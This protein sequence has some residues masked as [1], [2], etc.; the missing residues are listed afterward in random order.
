MNIGHI[1]W[2]AL[3]VSPGSAAAADP[4]ATGAVNSGFTLNGFGTL[5]FARSDND[6]AQYVRDLS[7]PYGLTTNG[8]AKV[9]SVLGLQAAYRFDN[10]LDGMLQAISRYRYDGSYRP[11]I[12]WAFLHYSPDP[13]LNLRVGRLG[14]EFYMSADSRLVGYA[15]LTVR[16]P[17]D[18]FG[19]LIFSYLDGFDVDLAR[20]VANGLLRGKLFAGY[21]PESSPF[22]GNI[23]W[24]L[25]GTLLAGGY[26]D[27]QT[28]PWQ[29]RLGHVQARF[30][31]E[32]P[33]DALVPGIIEAAPELSVSDKWARFDSLGVV[34]DPGPFQF[35]AMF[36]QTRHD[37]ATYE[38]TRAG[39]AIASYRIGKATP[40]LGY[41]RTLSKANRF[42]PTSPP[43]AAQIASATHSDQYTWFLGGRWDIRKDLDLKAQVDWVRGS[44]SSIFPFRGDP[45]VWDGRMT[46]FSLTL[47]FVF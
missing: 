6:Q 7:Q 1:L 38:D 40:Y 44:P 41:S 29:I 34:Y 12:S 27:Y 42:A 25:S 47:D 11:E 23:T 4:F 28:G 37:S 17:P 16:P 32:L 24:D 35:Q 39:Y 45:V 13:D 22:V 43:L 2:L 31:K 36:S 15:N 30:N 20:P 21:S 3:I 19:P 10:K 26:L 18:Y 33:L 5:G 8:T 46:V 9:D 14:T